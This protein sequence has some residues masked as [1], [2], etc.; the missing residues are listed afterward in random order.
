MGVFHFIIIISF[1][2]VL[3]MKMPLPWDQ[4]SPLAQLSSVVRDTTAPPPVAGGSGSDDDVV[5]IDADDVSNYNP[6]QI[7]PEDPETIQKI[8]S[9]LQPTAYD[10]AGGEYRKH[11]ASHVAGTGGWLTSSS[12]Y[13]DWLEDETNGL[14]WIKGIPGSGKSV[15][16]ANIINEIAKANP[17]CPVLFFFFRQIIAANHEPKALLR[18][19]MDQLLDYSPPLQKQL[20]G[21]KE[22][23][24]SIDSLS[25]ED[26]WKDL[27][28]AFRSL[29]GKVFCVADALDEM[30]QGNDLFL[31]T[32]GA[33]GNWKP[34]KVKVLITS[35]P[36]PAVEG[37]LRKTPCLHIRLEENMVDLDIST[38]VQFALSKSSIPKSEWQTIAN[39][40]P[41]RAN[42]LFL[43]AKLAMDAFLEPGADIQEVLKELPADL[44]VLYTDLLKEHAHR[45]GVAADIQHLILQAVTHATRPLRLLELAEMINVISSDGLTRDLKATK[46]L[47]RVA[48]GPLLE[49][50]ADETVSVV[51]H[52]FTEYLKG[53]TRS[54]DGSG[55]P[56]LRPGPTHAQL[57]LACLKYL[58]IG[59]LGEVKV[60]IDDT[61]MVDYDSDL[62][63]H[64]YGVRTAKEDVVGLR[65]KH[66]F[67]AY[68]ASNWNHHIDRSETAGHDQSELNQH[69]DRFLGE[70]QN[71]KAWLQL[72]WPGGE[73]K[74]IRVTPL[75]IAAKMCL[76][77]YTKQL[78]ESSDVNALDVDGKTPL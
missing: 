2:S 10:I 67:F 9:W 12:T 29:N 1:L 36:V 26:M 25:M 69:L 27:R 43:Y 35:R 77:S 68:A 51:H 7:L 3:L 56:I 8:R 60:N 55:Y 76:L 42:G 18:D 65:L 73:K 53:M 54:D 45:S 49:I 21:Y 66:P 63:Q 44:N 64:M 13:K 37:P 20:K 24:R 58:Q 50:L 52:S 75:H 71:R 34:G 4:A 6:K 11:L 39:A 16:A 61:E 57:A 59:C 23:R 31:Q 5:L 70:D 72:N 32:L 48:C 17:G 14:L 41:G 33:L 19:W 30:D 78:L 46:E 40:V 47:I 22:A 15:M 38:Y 62:D 28:M 74:A